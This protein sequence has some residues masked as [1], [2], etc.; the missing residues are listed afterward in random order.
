MEKP[1]K[2][3][4]I[5]AKGRC[6]YHSLSESKFS[7]TWGMLHK[8]IEILDL[9]VSKGDI[10]YEEVIVNKETILNSSY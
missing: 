10:Q 8:M 4:H 3:Y 7:E 5:Y 1:E 6:I 2:I 9:Q